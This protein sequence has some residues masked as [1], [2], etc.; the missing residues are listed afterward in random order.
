MEIRFAQSA[1]R[2]KIGRERVRQVIAAPRV[3]FEIETPSSEQADRLLIL[4]DDHT[5]R[6]LE[7]VVVSLEDGSLLVIHAMDLREKYRD[8]YEGAT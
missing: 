2:H 7:V 6:E 4:G 1:R 5:G 8:A 3:V